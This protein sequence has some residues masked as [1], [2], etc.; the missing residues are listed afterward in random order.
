[1]TIQRRELTKLVNSIDG[2]L[3]ANSRIIAG[4][5]KVEHKNFIALVENHIEH[6]KEFGAVAFQ[7]RVPKQPTGNPPKDYL[8]NEDQ[9]YFALTLMRNTQH[10]I[11]LKKRLVHEFSEARG[12]PRYQIE[13][14]IKDI[15]QKISKLENEPLTLLGFKQLS[16]KDRKKQRAQIWEIWRK[17][18]ANLPALNYRRIQV[19]RAVNLI[20]NGMTSYRF[21]QRTQAGG[22]VRDWMPIANQY[23]FYLAEFD[24]LNLLRERDFDV[25]FE[26]IERLY[27]RLAYAAKARV[28]AMHDMILSINIEEEVDRVLQSVRDQLAANVTPYVQT[29]EQVFSYQQDLTMELRRMQRLL[30]KPKIQ[31]IPLKNCA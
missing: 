13:K 9:C 28:E 2:E 3:R 26:F 5:A 17:V 20:V 14:N 30:L 11:V 25:D 31:R 15:E 19:A 1:M 23:A 10:A 24:L 4:F 29:V 22:L 6:F 27:P 12:N 16:L 18:G 21:R 7:T 8:L